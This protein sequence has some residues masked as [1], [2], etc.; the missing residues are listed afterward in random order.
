MFNLPQIQAAHAQVRSGADF[1]RYVQALRQLG[2]VCY[3]HFVA[4]GRIE[5]HGIEQVLTSA[6]AG[7]AR[8]V[9]AHGHP[10]QLRHALAAHQ[11]G[12]SDYPT[13]CQQAAAAGVEKWTT[14]ALHLTCTYYDRQGRA[15]LTE[16]IPQP[17]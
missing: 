7:P 11:Q 13:F 10:A 16:A 1:P 6:A 15:L 9:A 2:V 4:D 8:S 14:H 3:D 12:Q 17:A 5:Y